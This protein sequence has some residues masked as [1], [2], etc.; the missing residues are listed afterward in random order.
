MERNAKVKIPTYV[1]EF[2]GSKEVTF[3]KVEISLEGTK[4]E[5][6]KRFNEFHELN[7]ALKKNTGSLPPLPG[8][9]LLAVK[10]PE[11]IDRRR[12]GLEQYLQ[13][14]TGKVDV[15]ANPAFVKF[16]E[17]E[18][19]KPDLAINPL[20][21]RGSI[22]HKMM[23]YRDIVFSPDRKFYYSVTSD[24]S[25][26]SRIDSYVTNLNMPWDK[27]TDKEVVL[28]AVGNLEAWVRN[29]KSGGEFHYE[30]LWL[31]TFKTQAIC[32]DL[33]EKL[34]L[35]AVGC[36]N[37]TLAVFELDRRDPLQFSELLSEK[38]HN[39]RIMKVRINE[40]EGLIYTISEDKH[41]K[42]YDLKA[43]GVT[44]ELVVSK[45]K[46]AEMYVDS[47]HDIGYVS[48]RGGNIVVVN[49]ASNPPS[50]RQ[51]VRTSSD[52]SIRGLEVDLQT[53]RMYCSCFEDHY[54][55]IFRLVSPSDP[56]GRIEKI[57]SIKTSMNP[58]TLKW[59]PEKEELYIGHQ[60]GLISVINFKLNPNGPIYSGKCHD[61]NINTLQILNNDGL[62]ISGSGDKT[63]KVRQQSDLVLGA[64]DLVGQRARI[65]ACKE[66]ILF[67]QD[68]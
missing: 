22:T 48:D 12:D 24:P 9:T 52:G 65:L 44:H 1:N 2:E 6:K 35:I 33:C 57:Q 36:D 27:K 60:S 28:L 15:Y 11:E 37:G 43:Q 18:E 62:V 67:L 63:V 59:W 30:R 45:E 55:H 5:L 50:V 21:I 58:R 66:E 29:K 17:L 68:G 64:A 4:W 51:V 19:H 3:Y 54:V 13:A 41:L 39:A 47:K 38:I 25:T 7:E 32:L 46:L 20:D 53:K 26:I 8:K 10:K 61:G 23:G 34:N 14:L 42:I 56:E 16:L 31:K 40:K 49:L